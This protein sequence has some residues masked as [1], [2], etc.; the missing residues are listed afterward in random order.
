MAQKLAM[1]GCWPMGRH[2]ILQIIVM[3]NMDMMLKWM[4]MD[5]P[6]KS[7]DG[8]G[9]IWITTY[10]SHGYGWIWMNSI[11]IDGYG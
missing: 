7:A 1:H 6:C 10:F 11:F 2:S 3:D 8:Y 5:G 4:D 9:W